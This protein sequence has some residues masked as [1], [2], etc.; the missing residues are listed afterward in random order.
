ML[1]DLDPEDLLLLR[2]PVWTTD[3]QLLLG[4]SDARAVGWKTE[5]EAH[6]AKMRAA[7]AANPHPG[8]GGWRIP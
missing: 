5:D 7:E 6:A 3:D 4:R 1:D 2:A 8:P